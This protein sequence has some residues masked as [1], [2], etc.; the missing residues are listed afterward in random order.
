MLG[1]MAADVFGQG[2]RRCRRRVQTGASMGRGDSVIH[3]HGY[4]VAVRDGADGFEIND[5]AQRIADGLA[6]TSLI[7]S[8]ISFPKTLGRGSRKS[9]LMPVWARYKSE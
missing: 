4:A 6:N 1:T 3:H 5:V 2:V 8:S 7:L 9:A